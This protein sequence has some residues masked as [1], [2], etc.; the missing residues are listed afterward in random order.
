MA[1]AARA[2]IVESGKLLVMYR[3]KYG[4][5][6]FTLVGGQVADGETTEQALIRELKEETGLTVTSARQVFV[7]NHAEPY[8]QQYIYVCEVAP[9]DGVAIQEASEESYMNRLDANIHKP[10]WVDIAAFE[11]LPFR[12]P[13]LQSAILYGIH[14]GFPDQPV[15]L[16]STNYVA[17][18]KSGRTGLLGLPGKILKRR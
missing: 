10:L 16:S 5:E 9:H 17:R 15:D 13:S 2:I 3:N 14:K 1:K 6:Y 7:E 11:K 8:N 4:S 18:A 12:T